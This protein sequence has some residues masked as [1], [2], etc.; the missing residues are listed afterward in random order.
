MCICNSNILKLD[1]LM[2]YSI[3]M[4]Y[5]KQMWCKNIHVL[6]N[7]LYQ[8]LVLKV[9]ADE[10]EKF[11]APVLVCR[12]SWFICLIIYGNDGA[13]RAGSNDQ[14]VSLFQSR[15]H[16]LHTELWTKTSYEYDISLFSYILVSMLNVNVDIAIMKLLDEVTC[17]DWESLQLLSSSQHSLCMQPGFSFTS[18]VQ[19]LK[20]FLSRHSPAEQDRT[21]DS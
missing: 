15:S 9:T 12:Q 21:V 13:R 10:P 17:V 16:Y 5:C 18:L 1:I 20:S 7:S 11:T 6:V 8:T 19:L 4:H 2:K 3:I 14:Y